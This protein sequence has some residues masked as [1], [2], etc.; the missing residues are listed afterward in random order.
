MV[1]GHRAQ[2]PA[3]GGL[4][5]KECQQA[6]EQGGDRRGHDVVAVDEDAAGERVLQHEQRLPRVSLAVDLVVHPQSVYLGVAALRHGLLQSFCMSRA[7]S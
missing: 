5:E 4:L 1:V 2:R 3:R 7:T 6:H